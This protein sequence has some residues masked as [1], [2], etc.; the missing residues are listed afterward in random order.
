MSI[1]SAGDHIM[2]V[3]NLLNPG[4]VDSPLCWAWAVEY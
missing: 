1:R 2:Q 4:A 3:T